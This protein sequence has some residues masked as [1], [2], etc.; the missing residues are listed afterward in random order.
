MIDF[1][2]TSINPMMA[3]SIIMEKRGSVHAVIIKMKSGAEYIA[4]Y[5]TFDKAKESKDYMTEMI[6]TYLNPVIPPG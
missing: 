1:Q 5:E 4:E 6:D 2:N 3:E